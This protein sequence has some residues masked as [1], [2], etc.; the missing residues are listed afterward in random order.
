MADMILGPDGF[1]YSGS[2]A[3]ENI[4]T[5][6]YRRHGS[7]SSTSVSGGWNNIYQSPDWSIPKKMSTSDEF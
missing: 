5:P 1:S 4:G 3:N 6:F 2:T 7:N